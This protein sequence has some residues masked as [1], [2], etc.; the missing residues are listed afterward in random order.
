MS[1]S[2]ARRPPFPTASSRPALI[3]HGGGNSPDASAEA[4]ASHAAFLEVDL[5]VRRGRF[6]IRHERRIP[7]PL[8]LLFERWYL[9]PA[10]RHAYQLGDLLT[11]CHGRAGVLLDFKNGAGE[12]PSL[13]REALTRF[14]QGVHVLAS[15]QNWTILREVNVACPRIDCY[16]SIDTQEQLDLFHSVLEH[17]PLPM[18]VSCR[19]SLLTREVV[20]S[21]H[22]AGMA[23]LAWTVDDADRA[24]QLANWGVEAI[25][26][27]EVG[28]IRAAFT[29]EP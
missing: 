21:L 22:D 13:L 10:P 25:T 19:H 9:T 28:A 2:G 24:Q 15:S 16:Y 23:I 18:G 26:T 27:N 29:P 8:P 12:A 4:L 11:A 17:D 5:W 7:G 20:A 6:E 14:G 3:A 1:A